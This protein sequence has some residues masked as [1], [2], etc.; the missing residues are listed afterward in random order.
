MNVRKVVYHNVDAKDMVW[1][2]PH[3]AAANQQSV[4][5]VNVNAQDLLGAGDLMAKFAR[6]G[7]FHHSCAIFF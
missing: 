5:V 7:T 3:L 4:N 1:F 2:H 6:F